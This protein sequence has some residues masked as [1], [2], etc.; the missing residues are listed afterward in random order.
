MYS[1]N[2]DLFFC[3][4]FSTWEVTLAIY[5]A[6]MNPQGSTGNLL[7]GAKAFQGSLSATG[8]FVHVS[9]L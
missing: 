4:K 7:H 5:C 9:S 2:L 8:G 3:V 6:D 1:A